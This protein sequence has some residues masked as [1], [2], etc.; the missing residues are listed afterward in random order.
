MA[1]DNAMSL[2]QQADSLMEQGQAQWDAALELYEK[3]LAVEPENQDACLNASKIYAIRGRIPEAVKQY[4][5][6]MNIYSKLEQFKPALENAKRVLQL[7]PENVDVRILSIKIYKQLNDIKSLV[8]EQ[9]KL[10]RI[11]LEIG[12]GDESIKLLKDAQEYA[13]SDLN[14]TLQLADIAMSHGQMAEAINNYKIV[15]NSYLQRKEF[16]QALNAFRR[17]KVMASNDSRLLMTLGNLYYILGRYSEAQTEY[18]TIFQHDMTNR[19][20]FMAFGFA[21]QK[22]GKPR[23][24][25]LGFNKVIQMD[26]TDALALEKIG[27]INQDNNG[28]SEAVKYYLNSANNYMQVGE[29]ESAIKLYQRVLK[30]DSANSTANRELTTLGAP[31]HSSS[32][33]QTTEFNPRL[34]EITDYSFV[35]PNKDEADIDG[36]EH[37]K[38]DK[39]H[40]LVKKESGGG[41]KLMSKGFGKKGGA[42]RPMLGAGDEEEDEGGMFKSKFGKK[43]GMKGKASK[44]MLKSKAQREEEARLQREAELAEQRE[45]EAQEAKGKVKLSK[46]SDS[47]F[48]LE[49]PDSSAQLQE[50]KDSM[51]DPNLQPPS[52]GGDMANE[53]V[54][55]FGGSNFDN[56]EI[57]PPSFGE[58]PSDNDSSFGGFGNEVQAPSFGEAPSNNDSPFG[59]FGNEVQAPSFGEAPSS[60]DSPFGDFGNEVQAPSFGESP[61]GN[62]SPFGSFGNEVQAP[63]FG[64]AQTDTDSPFGSFGNDPQA[65]VFGDPMSANDPPFAGFGNDAQVPAFGES[66]SSNDSPF[67]SFG[68][69]VQAPAFGEVP[70]SN[71]SSFGGFGNEVQAPVFGEPTNA[72]A[73][74]EFVENSE[75]S[76]NAMPDFGD[77]PTFG[78]LPPLDSSIENKI[79]NNENDSPFAQNVNPEAHTAVF[80]SS[81]FDNDSLFAPS[82]DPFG[83]PSDP[84]ASSSDPFAPSS[85]PFASSSDPFTPSSVDQNTL[86]S[87]ENKANSSIFETEAPEFSVSLRKEGLSVNEPL[88]EEQSEKIISEPVAQDD[89]GSPFS[90]TP[91]GDDVNDPF[92]STP[93]GDDVNDPF[94]STPS[95]NDVNDPFAST[96]S[97]DLLSSPFA[98]TPSGD[99]VNDPFASTPSVEDVN[100]PFAPTPSVEDLSDPFASTPSVE[101]LSDPFAPTPSVEGLSDP[102]A[103]TPSVEGL[104]DPFASTPPVEDSNS[105]FAEHTDNT[106]I[107][108]STEVSS[109]T[110]DDITD[111]TPNVSP[112]A[113]TMQ[114]SPRDPA[115]IPTGSLLILPK[116]VNIVNEDSSM[117]SMFADLPF[118]K[119]EQEED[120]TN[121]EPEKEENKIS[122]IELVKLTGKDLIGA[123][124]TT[125]DLKEK[126]SPAKI[127]QERCDSIKEKVEAGDI[128]GAI[129]IY[130]Q[131]LEENPT[132]L[133]LRS[134]LAELYYTNGI[135][136]EALEQY[137]MLIE[138]EP[139]RTDYLQKL[140]SLGI[141]GENIEIA[142][143]NLLSM[144]QF[145]KANGDMPNAI[146]YYQS[147]LAV[148]PKNVEAR[149]EIVDI[150]LEQKMEKPALHHLNVLGDLPLDNT[151]PNRA[152]EILNKIQKYTGRQ[153]VCLKLAQAYDKAGMVDEALDSYKLLLTKYRENSD[154]ENIAIC[155][156]KIKSITPD[157]VT[158][159]D[160]LADIYKQL[161]QNDKLIENRLELGK[162]YLS[163]DM[164]NSA[165][166]AFEEIVSI[167]PDNQGA[168]KVLI[169]V[170][171]E[172]NNFDKAFEN[173]S[174]LSDIY[175]S[176]DKFDDA[177]ELYEN[178]ISKEPKHLQARDNLVT[179]YLRICKNEE[180][181]KELIFMADEY[182][183]TAQWNEAVSVYRRILELNPDDIKSRYA[184][185]CILNE[186]IGAKDEALDE[187]RKVFEIEP[188]FEE[189]AKS[190]IDLLFALKDPAGAMQVINKLIETDSSWVA[191]RDKIVDDFK[192][193]ATANKSDMINIF[194]LGIIYKELKQFDDAIKQ[195]QTTKKQAELF[196][197]SSIQLALCFSM[198]PGMR[199]LAMRTLSKDINDPRFNDSEKIE[200]KYVLAGFYEAAGKNKEALNLYIQVETEQKGY[201]DASEKIRLLNN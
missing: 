176:E 25:L 105:P 3:V 87:D 73:N 26:P 139:T 110:P 111:F 102:F 134:D 55:L 187:F 85:D 152:I 93:S 193:K 86:S 24:A 154:T 115:E 174:V 4:V 143:K 78:E 114:F 22:L 49:P 146:D 159:Y 109:A 153:D 60:N 150:Y 156:E 11:F 79:E 133:E 116:Q 99:D 46:E 68:N 195:F 124:S 119:S 39:S 6:L 81:A 42:G 89:L 76:F 169:D 184:L 144:A 57:Q 77:I 62:D 171:L 197:D 83:S 112:E 128:S 80:D 194:N 34:E 58:V 178:L 48:M 113:P 94:V 7:Q 15:A 132:N 12:K 19:E 18:R 45:K 97:G 173:I 117:S 21:S 104:S 190:Y 180:A 131:L 149:D 14:I 59:G 27:E 120:F 161:N 91:S 41:G 198:K 8:A 30:L 125:G 186:N 38:D 142:E 69:E 90:S 36:V 129:D 172:N 166:P 183:S 23:D 192:Q 72:N 108:D 162:Y 101:D 157:D 84:F 100:D 182:S 95:V 17:I 98:S 50:S 163:K 168:R 155:L 47:E 32:C 160:E 10:A 31:L 13:P 71:D 196:I 35:L 200:M 167:D 189:N 123:S 122:A 148:D 121:K 43:G 130:N 20:A 28:I 66:P 135:Y 181:L 164:Q 2:L 1:D 54:P 64:E 51:I 175:C 88:Q 170:F 147:V 191:Y 141:W 140:V 185:G 92:A 103:S 37:K 29:N 136:N 56:N 74:Q 63:A 53:E 9:I 199:S 118:E 65:P 40:M 16:E 106:P 33:M 179:I 5:T 107:F 137:S 127:Y 145:Y 61:S 126:L 75:M 138:K 96:S 82:S 151:E 70:S 67:G 201:K 177:I 158:V 165:I 188:T 44:P 52:F